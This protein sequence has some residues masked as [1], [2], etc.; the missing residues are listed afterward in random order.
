MIVGIGIDLVKV[1]RI[2]AV[3]SRHGQRFVER[4]LHPN[5]LVTY[6]DHSQPLAYFAKRYAAKEA[7]A[8]ALGTGIAKGVNFNE[9][10]TQLNDLGRPHLVLHGT[11]LEKANALGV[12]HSFITLSDEQD[13]AI[14]NVVLEG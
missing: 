6:Q 2:D 1:S 3:L 9:I 14:A 5:E 11:T 7:L 10:E 4:I 8:K 12:K 13:Y